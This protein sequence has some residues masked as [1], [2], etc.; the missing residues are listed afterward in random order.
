NVLTLNSGTSA[1]HWAVRLAGIG[2][3]DEV[4]TTP[5]TCTATNM[6]ILANGGKIVWA[7]VDPNSGLIDPLDVERKITKRTKAIMC[8]DWGGTP[9]HLDE[10]MRI[11]RKYGL[12]VIED[13]AHSIGAEYEG[14]KVGTIADFTCFSLQ[15]IKH[16]TSVDGGMLLLK[17]T[18]DYK[19]GKLL[20]WYGID[21]ESDRKDFRC[22]ENILDWGYKFHMND[23]N[24][25]IALHQFP[26]LDRVLSAH[27]GNAEYYQKN[28]DTEYFHVA[29]NFLPYQMLSSYWLFTLLFP[30]KRDR[31]NFMQYMK[32]RSVAVSQ[33][34]SRND[35]H[36]TFS[37]AVCVL[38]GVESFFERMCC[39]P[40]H[41]ALLEE[42]RKYIVDM[43]NSFVAGAR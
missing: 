4:I 7:D 42:E 41:W 11:G 8:V 19:R 18:S 15:A 31:L 26:H 9:C 40:V 25:T 1:L 3:G 33:V 29:T 2:H 12:K 39:I 34:H 43:A 17:D 16:I 38:P 24:A 21:R 10:L 6:P 30:E 28:L 5:M 32:K 37:N 35:T 13:A 36:T 20:R 14:R 23:V 27:R 22:E